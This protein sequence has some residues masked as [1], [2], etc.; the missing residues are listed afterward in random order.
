LKNKE[1]FVADPEYIDVKIDIIRQ[2]QEF[3]ADIDE[4]H[5][6]RLMYHLT[7]IYDNS[8]YEAFSRIIQKLIRELPT[9]ENLLDVLRE[10]KIYSGATAHRKYSYRKVVYRI[11][12]WKRPSYLIRLLKS[13]LQQTV[14]QLK[15]ILMNY[16]LI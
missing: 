16:V 9:L 2:M 1:Y 15:W 12:E 3:L 13:T 7:S 11:L 5:S 10:V 6:I 4:E 8:I 14:H